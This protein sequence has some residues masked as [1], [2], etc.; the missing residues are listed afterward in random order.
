LRDIGCTQLADVA[1]IEF[2]LAGT[3]VP[4][5]HDSAQGSGLAGAIAAQKD[6]QSAARDGQVDALQDVVFADVRVHAG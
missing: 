4:Q 5:S 2:D 3:G 1:A 6:C